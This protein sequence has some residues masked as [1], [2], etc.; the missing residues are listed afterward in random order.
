MQSRQEAKT[1]PMLESI[2]SSSS[3]DPDGLAVL[4]KGDEKALFRPG[5]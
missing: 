4:V 5:G 1:K 2:L 3:S